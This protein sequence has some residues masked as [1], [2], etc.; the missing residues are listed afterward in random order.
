MIVISILIGL[1]ILGLCLIVFYCQSVPT[2]TDSLDAFAMLRMG[3]EVQREKH[4]RFA[5]IRDT[6]KRD[7][8]DLGRFDG[9]VGV[10]LDGSGM[11]Q[12]GGDGEHSSIKDSSPLVRRAEGGPSTSSGI[13]LA[14]LPPYSST[15]SVDAHHGEGSEE[16]DERARKEGLEPPFR[17]AV[18][19]PGL[20]TKSMA[21]KRKARGQRKTRGQ[22]NPRRRENPNL[23][24]TGQTQV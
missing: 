16:G 8:E 4:V 17:L 1:Q 22:R 13:E 20:I 10:V 2:W 12:G 9:L 15:V 23:V 5:G 18:G 14:E 24:I 7:W 19:A 21:P 6:D 11:M 3:A